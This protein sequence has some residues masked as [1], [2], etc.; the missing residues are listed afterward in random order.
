MKLRGRALGAVMTAAV[1]V[2]TGAYA[3]A[4]GGPSGAPVSSTATQTLTES[5]TK[6]PGGGCSHGFWKNHL[7]S[8]VG[9]EPNTRLDSIFSIPAELNDFADDTAEEAL[10]YHGGKGVEG[11][12][13]LMLRTSVAAMLNANAQDVDA[14]EVVRAVNHALSSLDR[15]TLIASK[16]DLEGMS[17]ATCRN[18]TDH[19]ADD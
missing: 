17:H 19:T 4:N 8:W 14:N 9:I 2:A 12:A 10:R 5:P 13:R 18:D 3:V 7:D 1:I 11:G 16:A 6:A 15:G